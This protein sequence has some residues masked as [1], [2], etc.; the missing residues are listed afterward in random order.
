[1]LPGSVE[2]IRISGEKLDDRL[3]CQLYPALISLGL[4]VADQEIVKGTVTV[5][6]FDGL[7]GV[8]TAG[9]ADS[10]VAT[11]STMTIGIPVSDNRRRRRILVTFQ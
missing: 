1:V 5:A 6:P 8:G 3:T 7:T 9:A 10:D 2:P 11:L 4:R